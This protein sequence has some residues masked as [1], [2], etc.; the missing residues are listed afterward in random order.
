MCALTKCAQ[1]LDGDLEWWM[2]Y[3]IPGETLHLY[4]DKHLETRTS[5]LPPSSSNPTWTLA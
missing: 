4:Y 3:V 2:H 1:I 5:L